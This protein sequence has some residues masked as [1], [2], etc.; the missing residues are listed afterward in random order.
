[1]TPEH[2]EQRQRDWDRRI[3]E[4]G[5]KGC[6]AVVMYRGRVLVSPLVDGLCD[7]CL[8]AREDAASARGQG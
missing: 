7:R 3:S 1:M 5:C 4:F 8:A 6:G 2:L